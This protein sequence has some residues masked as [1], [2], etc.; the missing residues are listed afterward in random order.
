MSF[1]VY[2][3]VQSAK[4]PLVGGDEFQFLISLSRCFP[5]GTYWIS[6]AL[7]RCIGVNVVGIRNAV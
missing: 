7:A 5:F 6:P 4:R 3:A 2:C 1:F